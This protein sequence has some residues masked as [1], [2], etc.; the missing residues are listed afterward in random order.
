MLPPVPAGREPS[1]VQ[2]L[3]DSP[4]AP[5]GGE[6]G[7]LQGMI[8]VVRLHPWLIASCTIAFA[9]L[10]AWYSI[11]AVPVFEAITTMRIEES[12]ST[13]P[14]L[15]RNLGTESDVSTELEELR[16][17]SLAEE[18]TRR[19]SLQFRLVRPWV[20]RDALFTKIKVAEAAR[21]GSFE[22][23]RQADRR[24]DL[25]DRKTH[26]VLMR[27]V[28]GEPVSL[29][30]VS[31]TLAGGAGVYST[32]QFDIQ[33]F[34][35]AAAGMD[36][37][38]K[39]RQVNREARMVEVAYRDTDPQLVWLA[40]KVLVEEFIARRQAVRTSQARNTADFLR[41]QLDTLTA[42]L[43]ASEDEVKQYRQRHEV[44]NPEAEAS[45]QV[46]RLI[47]TQSRRGVIEAERTALSRLL[48]KIDQNA[49]KE[50]DAKSSPYAQVL[51]FPTLLQNRAATELLQSLATVQDQRRALL[52]RRTPQDPDVQAL[53][54]RERELQDQIRS[55]GTTYL[56]G[57]TNQVAS[58]DSN[59][60]TL[61]RQLTRLP[62]RELEVN[63]LERRPRVLEQIAAM[64]QTRLKEAEITAA[65][66][67]PSVR[68]VDAAIAPDSPVSP[69]PK[70]NVLLG[71][72]G[73]LCFGFGVAFL[74]EFLDK[75][76]RSRN[77][78]TF[79]T[80]LP[81]LGLIPRI[82]RSGAS[83]IAQAP[84][85]SVRGDRRPQIVLPPVAP[86]AVPPGAKPDP[87][88]MPRRATYTFLP[89][90]AT[91]QPEVPQSEPKAE[92]ARTDQPAVAPLR[93]E[94]SSANSAAAEAYSILRT[95]LAFARSDLTVKVVVFTSPMPGEGK[96]TTTV[97]LALAL[98]QRG[99]RTLLIDADIRR[100]AVH[101]IF[102]Q[103]RSP[104]LTDVLQGQR[105]TGEV[106][107]E[108]QVGENCPLYYMPVGHPV[109][110]P[111]GLVE[112]EA[113][114][115]LLASARE[116][117]DT[118]IIDSSPVNIVTDAALL[119]RMADGVLVV[120]RAGVTDT[121]ALEHAL[122][123]LRHVQAPVLGVVLNDIDF[124]RYGPYDRAYKYYSSHNEYLSSEK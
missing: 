58:L 63:R 112:S 56:E 97:N 86:P 65:E 78:V 53:T 119:G 43:A 68:V 22:L 94:L 67:D 80:G 70:R 90:P 21:P 83:V 36:A 28:T 27:V 31:F 109:P 59:L 74:R 40:P 16:S 1:G 57:L 87:T 47:E 89:L 100:G 49:A 92:S 24:F 29:P 81:V 71:L 39:V 88:V 5:P 76:V 13:V 10:A 41:K 114:R 93:W 69:N 117:Y 79:A 54:A 102:G 46:G 110:S 116:Q 120:A 113:M 25:I 107:R 45:G 11:R 106:L 35:G 60:A 118:V 84:K 3:A 122:E 98:A 14:E 17:R 108:V 123:Q 9:A 6:V 103:S 72:L 96:T 33:G 44:I 2:F 62:E 91:P 37:N 124:E 99:V 55:I 61:N 38:L 30:G 73:G 32:I 101:R 48:A 64:L 105:Q 15:L 82:G 26:D 34:V 111:T 104:G 20:R 66:S 42:Q 51:A 115:S 77:D 7:W 19:L 85:R 95:N 12:R 8:A 50:G 121:D 75:S 23:R 52:A 18:V 4:G